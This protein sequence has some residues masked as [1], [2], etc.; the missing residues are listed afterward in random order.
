MCLKA[1][2]RRGGKGSAAVGRKAGRGGR[3][4]AGGALDRLDD[5]R[6]VVGPLEEG[7]EAVVVDRPQQV[8]EVGAVLGEVLEVLRDHVERRLE[9]GLKDARHLRGTRRRGQ[10][11]G[12]GRSKEEGGALGRGGRAW[13]GGGGGGWL[14]QSVVKSLLHNTFFRLL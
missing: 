7:G 4:G 13:G 14:T 9:D 3:A 2:L 5:Q 11:R 12:R 6:E 10:G 8:E 1:H